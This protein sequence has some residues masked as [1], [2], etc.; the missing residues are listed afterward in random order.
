MF[1]QSIQ[2]TCA[3]TGDG[4]YEGLDWLKSA[5]ASKSVKESVVKPV[6]ETKETL[7][8]PQHTFASLYSSVTSYFSGTH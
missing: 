2:S 4:L 8:K 1:S 3:P 5:L 6:N 7:K